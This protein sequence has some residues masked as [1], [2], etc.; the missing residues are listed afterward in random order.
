MESNQEMRVKEQA[1]QH[2]WVDMTTLLSQKAFGKNY[3][4]DTIWCPFSYMIARCSFNFQEQDDPMKKNKWNE[5]K[6]KGA[7]KV[8]FKLAYYATRPDFVDKKIT[9]LYEDRFLGLMEKEI[10]S[11]MEHSDIP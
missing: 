1:L 9:V 2:R 3:R 10:I 11:F 8:I 6:F 7:D 5:T 4:V